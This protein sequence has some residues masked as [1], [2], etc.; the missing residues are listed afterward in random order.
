M[1]HGIIQLDAVHAQ[2][3]DAL[4]RIASGAADLDNGNVVQLLTKTGQVWA[5]TAPATTTGLQNLW[6]VAEP[7]QV[8]TNGAFLN[9]DVTP[10]NFYVLT[11]KEFSAFKPQIADIITL[12][13]DSLGGTLGSNTHV[14]ATAGTYELTWAAAVVA[15]LSLKLVATNYIS[16]ATGSINTQRTVAYQFEVVAIA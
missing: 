11:G 9:I 4:N 14:V 13:A 12:T 10:G 3:I 7:V 16:I 6:M 2:N 5:A 1:A 15:G 8:N